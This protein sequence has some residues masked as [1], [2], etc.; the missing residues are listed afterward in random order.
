MALTVAPSSLLVCSFQYSCWASLSLDGELPL[1]DLPLGEEPLGEDPSSTELGGIIALKSR[2]VGCC[3]CQRLWRAR[4]VLSNVRDLLFCSL[5]LCCIQ[6]R[7]WVRKYGC[8][9]TADMFLDAHSIEGGPRIFIAA[10][11][12]AITT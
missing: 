11:L 9:K 1:G 7:P 10:D 8:R 12:H 6:N 2:L 4:L 3:H 5:P